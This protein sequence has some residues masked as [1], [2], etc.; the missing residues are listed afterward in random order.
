MSDHAPSTPPVLPDHAAGP[1]TAERFASSFGFRPVDPAEKGGLVRAVFDS[2]APRYDL[3]NDLMSLGVHR[4]WKDALVDWLAPRAGMTLIDVAG[5][6]GDI[7]RRVLARIGSGKAVKGGAESRAIICDINAA[8]LTAGRQRSDDWQE[9]SQISWV[10]G[11]A[12]SLPFADRT[13]DAYTIAFGI[14]NVTRLDRALAEARRVLRRGGRF[15]CL[16]FGP[17]AVPGLDAIYDA[18]SFRVLPWLGRQVAS[19]EE[20]YRYLAE[21]IRKFP[22]PERFAAL[23][24]GAGL[25]RVRIR[26]LSGGIATLYSAW[27]L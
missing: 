4:L 12:E 11:D 13:A 3:M 7:A 2:V 18:Y 26:R 21:S 15:L 22:A 27:R 10:A 25:E 23:M 9:R 14:R 8:M 16:E 6:T 19:D 20:A 24:T 17:V 1:D 5:G